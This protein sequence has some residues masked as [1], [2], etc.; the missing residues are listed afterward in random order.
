[1]N[2]LAG[3]HWVR[4]LIGGFL[5]EVAVFAVVLPLSFVLGQRSLLYTA[6]VASLA[7]CFVLALWVVR[8]VDS[9]F[10]LHGVLVGVVAALLYIALTRAQ[11]E[12]LAYVVAHVLKIFGGAAGGLVGGRGRGATSST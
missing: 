1:M 2:A 5:A 12:P 7:A 3:I 6:P 4:A 8:G 11:P 9:R 10:V